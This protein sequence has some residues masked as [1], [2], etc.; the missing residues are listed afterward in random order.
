[1]VDG[2]LYHHIIDSQTLYPAENYRA[3]TVICPDSGLADALSTALFLMSMEEGLKLLEKF[4]SEAIW[5]DSAGTISYSPG[6]E[7]YIRK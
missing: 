5:I 4:D 6:F 7:K 2:K 1:M 3:V